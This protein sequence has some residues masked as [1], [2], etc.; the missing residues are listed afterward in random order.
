[1]YNDG[2]CGVEGSFMNWLEFLEK[3]AKTKGLSDDEVKVLQARFPTEDS[4]ADEEDVAKKTIQGV[5]SVGTKMTIIYRNFEKFCPELVKDENKTKKGKALILQ[6]YLREL[7]DKK[8]AEEKNQSLTRNTTFQALI[9]EKTR[10]FCGRQFVFDDFEKFLKQHPRGYFTIVGEPGMG[11]SAIAAKAVEKYQTIHYFNIL[12][13]NRCRPEAFLKSVREQL[14]ARYPLENADNDNLSDLLTKVMAKYPQTE[15][16]LIIVDALDEVVDP[17]PGRNILDLPMYLPDRVYF[18]LT[19]RGY[20]P[21]QKQL[22]V[23]PDVAMKD[24][25]LTAME[26]A[27]FNQD[28]V[29]S[30]IKLFLYEDQQYKDKLQQWINKRGVTPEQFVETLAE[31]SE[32]NFM[33]LRYV[34]PDIGKGKY[35]KDFNINKLPDGLEQYY[36]QQWERLMVNR[37]NALILCVLA[38]APTPI[39]CESITRIISLTQPLNK[40]DASEV[41]KEWIQFLREQELKSETCY[42]IY[43]KSF[44]EFLQRQTKLKQAKEKLGDIEKLLSDYNDSLWQQ[45]EQEET[46]EDDED[47]EEE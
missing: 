2:N 20:T 7:Y 27:N 46:E 18:M 12:A 41:L 44:A 1:V 29:K 15:R 11:K 31:K 28:D 33:Y 47:G 26:Y 37:R 22:S 21:E 19:R 24:L 8:K 14:L 23:S 34:L 17:E 25:D 3:I 9:T 4:I 39:S 5:S 43:H 35:D 45:M 16:L 40:H 38:Y 42:S 30:Y 32:N 10:M 13:E 36:Y 6:K